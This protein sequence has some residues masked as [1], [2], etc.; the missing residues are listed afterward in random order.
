VSGTICVP[1]SDLSRYTAFTVALCC[2]DKPEGTVLSVFSS[3][4]VADN[5]N[6]MIED[7][8]E[9]N[10]SNEWIW[11]MGDDHFWEPDALMKML[12][13]QVELDADILVPLVCKRNPPWDLVVMKEQVEDEGPHPTWQPYRYSEIPDDPFEIAA[14]GSAGMLIQQHVLDKIGNP[15]FVSTTGYRL[16]EDVEFCR[17]AKELGFT[18]WCDPRVALSHISSFQVR[19]M[20][21]EDGVWGPMTQFSSSEEKYRSVF[22]PRGALAS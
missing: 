16:N 10:P 4:S 20:R 19:P 21:N 8:T 17:R 13:A 9:N 12:A 18:L 14:A 6:A 1:A 7:I 5:L 2:T 11:V 3:L 22:F 15:W